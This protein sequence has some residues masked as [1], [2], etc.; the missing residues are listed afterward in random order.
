MARTHPETVDF[1]LARQPACWIGGQW[2]TAAQTAPLLD[3]TTGQTRGEMALATPELVRAAVAAARWAQPGWGRTPLSRRRAVLQRWQ[4][5]LVAG[6][7]E[8]MRLE[9]EETGKPRLEALAT[10]VLSAVEGVRAALWAAPRVLRAKRVRPGLLEVHYHGKQATVIPEP[11]GVVAAIM[12]WNFPLFLPAGH[13][14][15]AL[16]AGNT[17]VLKPSDLT[18]YTSLALA[19]LLHQAGLPPGC[20]NVVTGMAPTG[21]ALA[22]A[23]VDKI[24]FTGSVATGRAVAA[25][26]AERLAPVSLELGGKDAMIVLADADP[27]QAARGAVWGG[28]FNAGQACAS[29]E[30]IYVVQPLADAFTAAL[31]RQVRQL[32]PAADL[33]P[34]ISAAQRDRVHALVGD[35]VARGACVLTGG[36]PLSGSSGFYYE[37]TVL[38]G[39]R[40]EMRIMQEEIFGPVLPVVPVSGPQEAVALANQSEFGLTASLWTR[41]VAGAR[42][43]GESLQV[44]VVTV[45]EHAISAAWSRLPWGGIK[46]SGYGRSM[47][48]AGLREYVRSRVVLTDRRRAAKFWWYPYS[49][50][51]ERFFDVGA[52]VLYSLSP[53]RRLRAIPGTLDALVR[54]WRKLAQAPGGA[55]DEHRPKP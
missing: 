33:G 50:E 1:T 42:R 29:V 9:A 41:D 30:R 46:Q 20:L 17:V 21:Q 53:L 6:R 13:I 15:A 52:E 3:P 8:L 40:P 7:G 32:R 34:L 39:V 36:Q 18:P 24:A 25:A 16:L 43:L 26:A 5:L 12:P 11:Y 48:E 44:G 28:L 38:T 4:E 55:A 14:A 35:A 22:A 31:V 51:Q 37:P 47:G 19:Q 49:A 27:E 2:V 23:A 45:N 10:G 54:L